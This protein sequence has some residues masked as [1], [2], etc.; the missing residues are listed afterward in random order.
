MFKEA[1]QKK[2]KEKKKKKGKEIN[3]SSNDFNTTSF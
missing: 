3:E 2:K 1:L